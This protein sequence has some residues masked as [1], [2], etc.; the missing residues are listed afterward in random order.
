M[1]RSTLRICYG[2]KQILDTLLFKAFQM[3]QI[4]FLQC[5]Q[6]QYIMDEFLPDKQFNDLGAKPVYV[7]TPFFGKVDDGVDHSVGAFEVLTL[8]ECSLIEQFTAAGRTDGRSFNRYLISCTSLFQ[9]LDDLGDDISASY[10]DD[11]VPDTDIFSFYF[12]KIMQSGAADHG[13]LYIDRFYLCYRGNDTGSSYLQGDRL[14]FAHFLNGRKLIGT[15]P[16][17]KLDGISKLLL[18]ANVIHFDDH[19][20]H[21]HRYLVTFGDKEPIKR[22]YLFYGIALFG[23]R[24]SQK[25][26]RI[27]KIHLFRESCLL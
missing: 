1:K 16:F 20:I 3:F 2:L 6:I 15:H 18:F 24:R 9:Y 19:A 25:A 27:D 14:Y 23:V 21:H 12:I 17:G 8:D 26:L 22:L 11:R 4:F 5:I 7:H 10:D 13:T